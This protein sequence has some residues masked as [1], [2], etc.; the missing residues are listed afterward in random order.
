L[1]P[2]SAAMEISL[3]VKENAFALSKKFAKDRVSLTA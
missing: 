1:E 3:G 2:L